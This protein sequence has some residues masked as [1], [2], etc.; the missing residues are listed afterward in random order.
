M[1]VDRPAAE[2][3]ES[4]GRRPRGPDARCRS[5]GVA[6]LCSLRYSA[7]SSTRYSPGIA[8]LGQRRRLA[9]RLAHARLE[10]ARQ[11]L[12]LV[13]GVVDVELGGHAR[14]PRAQQPRER[15]TDRRGARVDDHER[16]G[17]I[18]GDELQRARAAR[19]GS[20]PRPYAAPAPRISRSAPRAPRGR[21]EHVEEAGARDLE[22]LHLGHRREVLDDGLG[23]LARRAA[24]RRAPA[25][26]R[27]WSRSRRAR[28]GAALPTTHSAIDGNPA[29]ASAV[30]TPSRQSFGQAHHKHKT[31]L[32]G[33][34]RRHHTASSE[35]FT[36]NYRRVASA[37]RVVDVASV[38]HVEPS[39]A[40]GAATPE[41]VAS[42]D[43]EP[44]SRS[45][46]RTG[47]AGP[48]LRRIGLTASGQLAAETGALPRPKRRPGLL[49]SVAARISAVPVA[50]WAHDRHDHSVPSTR[51]V[52]ADYS[53]I[54]TG[55]HQPEQA[56]AIGPRRQPHARDRCRRR[57]ARPRARDCRR[58]AWPA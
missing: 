4:A 37:A 35:A 19:P 36:R 46:T 31:P 11:R 57:R 14:A 55:R 3:L 6:S 52:R 50:R 43:V 21:E 47:Y 45:A 24:W 48:S 9:H 17:G 22:P 51:L 29:A 25:P 26:S 10:R 44:G 1:R 2:V 27:R 54:V 38:S 16:A 18:G 42:A 30:C 39:A 12:E 40:A 28:S 56:S 8:V 20:S 34:D 5:A 13:A 53:S 23:D 32:V 49:G 33:G 7:A 41:V 15:V 58:R